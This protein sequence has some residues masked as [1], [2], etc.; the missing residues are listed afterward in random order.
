M[1]TWKATKNITVNSRALRKIK[2]NSVYK[3][4]F[5]HYVKNQF[6]CNIIS[7]LFHL[8]SILIQHKNP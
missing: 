7:M 6:I 8:Q 3:E 2:S 4:E 5:F 1:E